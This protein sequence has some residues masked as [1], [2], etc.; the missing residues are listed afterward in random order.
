MKFQ[1]I[2]KV[3]GEDEI[4]NLV[5]QGYSSERD[6]VIHYR[7]QLFR[8][9]IDFLTGLRN[10]T[11]NNKIRRVRRRK[12]QQKDVIINAIKYLLKKRYGNE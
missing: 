12:Y 10:Y 11:R 8:D 1:E 5:K 9:S 6:I 3:L 7:E 2:Y 4:I